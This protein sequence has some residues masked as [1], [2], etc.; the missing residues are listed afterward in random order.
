MLKIEKP[1]Y[2]LVPSSEFQLIS[3]LSFHL[4]QFLSLFWNEKVERKT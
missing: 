1:Y 2:T 4:K 3:M